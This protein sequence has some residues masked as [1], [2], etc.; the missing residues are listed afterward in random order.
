MPLY[1]GGAN[2]LIHNGMTTDIEPMKIPR[3]ARPTMPAQMFAIVINEREIQ[4]I[5]PTRDVMNVVNFL[6][7]ELIRNV[8]KSDP[9]IANNDD[10]ALNNV[11]SISLMFMNCLISGIT[12]DG[13]DRTNPNENEPR[14]RIIEY[15]K[16]MLQ[17]PIFILAV[18]KLDSLIHIVKLKRKISNALKKFK[19]SYIQKVPLSI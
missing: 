15:K 10:I 4:K 7:T 18:K 11:A 8:D 17:N 5:H 13:Y 1:S 9:T 12:G 3:I 16:L 14:R 6:P 2:S 19:T